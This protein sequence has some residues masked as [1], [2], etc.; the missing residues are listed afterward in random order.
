[1]GGAGGGSWSATDRRHPQIASV[2][3]SPP[4][5]AA[6][7]QSS[8]DRSRSRYL[9]NAHPLGRPPN[10]QSIRNSGGVRRVYGGAVDNWLWACG[11]APERVSSHCR[12]AVVRGGGVAGQKVD[13]RWCPRGSSSATEAAWADPATGPRSQSDRHT[14]AYAAS[15]RAPQ[16]MPGDCSADPAPLGDS[17]VADAR[18]LGDFG[19]ADAVPVGDCGRRMRARSAISGERMPWPL[20]DCGK[21]DGTPA[22]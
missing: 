10:F 17:G 20:G 3:R 4:T 11:P 1:M 5:D 13:F 15:T 6:R 22:G 14:P 9:P 19:R 21:A 12:T 16:R 7:S 2:R 8:A 18:P